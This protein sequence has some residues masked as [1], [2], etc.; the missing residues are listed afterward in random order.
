MN[1]N[2]TVDGKPTAQAWHLNTEKELC[3][4]YYCIDTLTIFCTSVVCG[5]KDNTYLPHS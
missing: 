3:R 2:V 4:Y 1:K 5:F